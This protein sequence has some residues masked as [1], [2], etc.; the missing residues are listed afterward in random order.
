M[1]TKPMSNQTVNQLIQ[2]LKE[3]RIQETKVLDQLEKARSQKNTGLFKP[4]LLTPIPTSA[5]K[6]MKST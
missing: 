6:A 4:I 1:S 5:R 3:I 2:K